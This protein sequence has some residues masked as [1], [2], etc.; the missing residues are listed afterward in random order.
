MSL[1]YLITGGGGNLA[2]PLVAK[3]LASG[4]K[5]VALD[6]GEGDQPELQGA[7]YIKGDI[8][9]YQQVRSVIDEHRPSQIFHM[10]S[11]L[12]GSSEIDRPRSWDINASAS[13][14]LMELALE[15]DVDRFFFPST[16]A[17]YGSD[18]ADPLPEDFTQWPVT[19]YGVTKV[20]VER[21]GAYYKQV[22][23]LDFRCFRLPLVLS[24]FAPVGALTAYASHAFVAAA[25]GEPYVF[26]VKSD[27]GLSTIYVKDVV[28][29]MI[30]LMEA[31]VDQ[32]QKPVYNVHSISPSAGEIGTAIKQKVPG[33]EFSFKPDPKVAKLVDSL[34]WVHVDG[35]ARSHWGWNPKFS[36]EDI[37]EDFFSK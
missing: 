20:L 17:T 36:L 7:T 18:L 37:A 6:L 11:L 28:N 27:S 35:A 4:S 29:G 34:S 1:C 21:A 10:A 19:F 3:L 30:K 25:A 23:G 24:P 33:F 32:I 14:H 16:G 26:P 8:T 9:D 31:P 12:S 15:F 5:V 2:R 13:V 22:H